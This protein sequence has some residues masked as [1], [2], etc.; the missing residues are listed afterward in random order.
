MQPEKLESDSSQQERKE[1]WIRSVVNLAKNFTAGTKAF[2]T[3]V[4]LLV[5]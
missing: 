5:A 1:V 3:L 4:Y 2:V